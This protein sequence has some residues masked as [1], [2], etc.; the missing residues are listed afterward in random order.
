MKSLWQD[1]QWPTLSPSSLAWEGGAGSGILPPG[2]E[3]P[4]GTYQAP[5]W[6]VRPDKWTVRALH[7]SL[8]GGPTHICLG[9]GRGHRS[10]SSGPDT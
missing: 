3:G 8:R 10:A 6:W 7:G 5:S 9:A 4:A 1:G 2:W